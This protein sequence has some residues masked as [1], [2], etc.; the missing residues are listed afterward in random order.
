MYISLPG[1]PEIYPGETGFQAR[2]M[3]RPCT[4]RILLR[5]LHLLSVLFANTF[6]PYYRYLIRD[7][8]TCYLCLLFSLLNH[9]LRRI[10]HEPHFPIICFTQMKI[11]TVPRSAS[12]SPATS[13]RLQRQNFAGTLDQL[14]E[15]HFAI[16][17]AGCHRRFS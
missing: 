11:R 1:L 9:D 14:S 17:I 2:Q 10:L 13:R 8:S 6:I 3:W 4:K 15:S 16:C 7:S 5:C 12:P